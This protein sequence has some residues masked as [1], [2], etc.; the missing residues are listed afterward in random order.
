M[1][2]TVAYKDLHP[3]HLYTVY[4]STVIIVGFI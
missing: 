3:E 4:R 1:I 2:S